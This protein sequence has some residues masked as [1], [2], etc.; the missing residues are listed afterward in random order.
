MLHSVLSELF[1]AFGKKRKRKK[2]LFKIQIWNETVLSIKN[3]KLIICTVVINMFTD[4]QNL[5]NKN[6]NCRHQ[7]LHI[8][9]MNWCIDKR[10]DSKFWRILLGNRC[11][12]IWKA[13]CCCQYRS[14]S[15]VLQTSCQFSI[16]LINIFRNF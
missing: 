14:K 12:V 10:R 4:K 6:C 2:I 11:I 1:K 8:F 7:Y 13:L 16:F 9:T 3:Q 5:C 15:Y